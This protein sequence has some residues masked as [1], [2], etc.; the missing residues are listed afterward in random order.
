MRSL[1]L[2][3]LLLRNLCLT[4]HIRTR[5]KVHTRIQLRTFTNTFTSTEASTRLVRP[6]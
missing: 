2:R 1:F 4:S 6:C 3:I 5:I